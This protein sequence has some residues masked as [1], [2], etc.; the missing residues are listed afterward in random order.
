M[1][2]NVAVLQG[3]TREVV[4]TGNTMDLLLL[5]KPDQE[6]DGTFK[7]WDCD[8]Q[9]FITINGWLFAFEEVQ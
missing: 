9:E 4:A 5:V 2:D 8:A 1:S 3:Y 7:A 6:F